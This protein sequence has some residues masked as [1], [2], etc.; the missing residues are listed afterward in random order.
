MSH[1]HRHDSPADQ[2]PGNPSPCS[3]ALEDQVAGDFE[4]AVA[5]EEQARALAKLRVVQAEILLQS[6]CGESDVDAIE[7]GNDV[8]NEG[9]RNQPPDD[10]VH[11]LAVNVS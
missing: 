10:A 11:H 3:D 1:A 2:D 4:E 5:D 9:E 7:V 6:G 8:T